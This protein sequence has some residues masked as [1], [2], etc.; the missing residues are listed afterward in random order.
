MVGDVPGSISGFQRLGY[1]LLLVY[2][3]LSY[4]RIF[5]VKFGTLHIPGMTV[6]II[7]LMTILSRAFLP[8]LKHSIGRAMYFFTFWF[9]V[10]IPFSVWRSGSWNVLTDTWI[11]SFVVFLSTSGLLRSFDQCKKAIY[12]VGYALFV[13][14]LIAVLWGSTEETGR[15][16]LPNGKFSNPNEMAQALLL[17]IPLWWLMYRQSTSFVKKSISVG[18]MS[19]MLLMISKCGS[20]GALITVGVVVLIVFLRASIIGKTKLLV[21]GTVFTMLLVAITPTKLLMRYR[22][23]TADESESVE[24]ND[25]SGLQAS[26][27][28]SSQ[29][30]RELLRASIKFTIRHPLFGVGPGMF[31]VAEDFDAKAR[32]RRKGSWQGTHNSYTQVSSEM[33]L[34]GAFAYI[35]VIVISLRRSRAIHQKS[36]NDPRLASIANCALALNYC[37]II[38]AVSVFFDY[39]AYTAMLSAY[40]GLVMA[41]DINAT[42]EIE[43]LR[44]APAQPA[45]IGF[46]EYTATMAGGSRTRTV[47]A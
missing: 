34:A 44:R 19:L 22:T 36:C 43:R 11:Y 5:D 39:I 37:I 41:L 15:L 35:A 6:R 8:A 1:L 7:I 24:S 33:G 26:A 2:L 45:P 17:G 31:P 30:R 47:L 40:S 42:A 28:T 29:H 38:Y 13:L 10:C 21:G 25:D 20:R 27:I 23:I 3:F 46:S 16:F 9:I 32:G 4:S 12:A 18:V 14:T